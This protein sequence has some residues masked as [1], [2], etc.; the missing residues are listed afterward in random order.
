[1]FR[2]LSQQTTEKIY[3]LF[4]YGEWLWSREAAVAASTVAASSCVHLP[5]ATSAL[6]RARASMYAMYATRGVAPSSVTV[7]AELDPPLLRALLALWASEPTIVE[8]IAPATGCGVA[9]QAMHISR[10]S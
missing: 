7:T 2:E 10:R 8:P 6:R 3:F 9:R 1:M 5:A 4:F